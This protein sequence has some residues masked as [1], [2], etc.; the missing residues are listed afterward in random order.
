MSSDQMLGSQSATARCNSGSVPGRDRIRIPSQRA[1]RLYAVSKNEPNFLR[2]R[3]PSGTPMPI[4]KTPS[5]RARL[6]VARKRAESR[7]DRLG[8]IVISCRDC[9]SPDQSSRYPS[10]GQQRL[11]ETVMC[12][13]ARIKLRRPPPPGALRGHPGSARIQPKRGSSA[14]A[15]SE[16][17]GNSRGR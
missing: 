7:C 13:T 10:T 8:I 17:E 14:R 2:R 4:A 15:K 6:D 1:T 11:V 3:N 12:L 5:R 16:R 9:R